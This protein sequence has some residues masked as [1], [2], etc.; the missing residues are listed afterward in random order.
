M[1]CSLTGSMEPFLQMEI[2]PPNVSKIVL[3]RNNISS[4]PTESM[5]FVNDDVK[6][7]KL[8]FNEIQKLETRAVGKSFPML[9][10]L[11]LYQN[12]IEHIRRGD[13]VALNRLKVLDLGNNHIVTI[14][15]G[16]FSRLKMLKRLHLDGNR[17]QSLLPDTFFGLEGLHELKLDSNH[18]T[19]LDW[20]WLHHMTSL[21]ELMVK[22][23]KIRYIQPF[24]ITWQ[25]SLKKINLSDNQIQ[26]LPNLPAL[27]NINAGNKAGEFWY[28]DLNDNPVKC[29]CFMTSL[30]AFAWKNLN[31]AVCGIGMKCKL[32]KTTPVSMAQW[33]PENQCNSSKR[34]TFVEKFLKTSACEEPFLR[35][36]VF[37]LDLKEET[38]RILLCA[39]SGYGF[40][41]V[42]IKNLSDTTVST[43]IGKN[44]AISYVEGN[45]PVSSFQCIAENSVGLVRS[46]EWTQSNDKLLQKP[47]TNKIPE[48]K[49][50]EVVT[51]SLAFLFTVFLL[52]ITVTVAIAVAYVWMLFSGEIGE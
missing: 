15:S 11:E 19:I 23:N 34:M 8:A 17:L 44:I 7:L 22:S 47:K 4:F 30:A 52:C 43:Q 48:T 18:L 20:K 31:K 12:K 39:A 16:S 33:T 29:N 41:I 38:S 49:E 21:E 9:V 32:E 24:N 51:I 26:Y 27:E 2:L 3:H 42:Q 35:L 37:R 28:L 14:E 6:E 36:K 46:S 10:A 25:K 13:S 50:H 45:E 5:N 1:D 40:P